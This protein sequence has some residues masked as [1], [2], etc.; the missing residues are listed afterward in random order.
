MDRL[1][2][3]L[4]RGDR[5]ARRN[6][7]VLFFAQA[8]LGSQLQ[9]TI[10]LSGLAGAML[11]DTPLLATL[12]ISLVMFTAVFGAPLASIFMGK[13]GRRVGFLVG[14]CGGC[15]G[16]VLGTIALLLS[17]FELLLLS[18][19]FTGVYYSFH[20]FYRFAAADTASD[21][22]R[23]KAISWVLAG[24]L[25]GAI[26]GSEVVQNFSD[27]FAPTPFAGAYAVVV[28]LN[29]IGAIGVLFLDIPLPS[30]DD[31]DVKGGRPL[32]VIVRQ[33]ETMIAILCGMISYG[34]MALVMTSTSLAMVKHEFTSGQAADVVRWHAF[35]MFGPSFV[36]GTIIGRFGTL[37]VMGLG[38]LML[39][40]SC[41]IGLSGVELGQFYGALIFLGFGWNF[42]FIGATTL[43]SGTYRA[44]E[45][46]KVQGL[47]DFL[48]L[49]TVSMASFLSGVLLNFYGWPMVQVAV[50]PA[51]AIAA[52]SLAWLAI[53]RRGRV[54]MT[55]V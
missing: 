53:F 52:I 34:V 2:T 37:R 28:L 31:K 25:V 35:F 43:L 32:G 44:N 3:H 11:A 6:V 55:S 22:F 36:T 1:L 49:G 18:A 10:V 14:A 41:F 24:G 33:P 27:L 46:A 8:V 17:S 12:P 7:A 9:I 42:S 48:V 29:V 51:L 5:R 16:G 20:G 40:I 54:V 30:L 45:R 21:A 39:G 13:F 50:M 26:I 23:P 19:I 38:L 47:N 15:V 4:D